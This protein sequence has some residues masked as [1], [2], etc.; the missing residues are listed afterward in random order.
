V[1]HAL[2][3]PTALALYG[4]AALVAVPYALPA[5]LAVPFAPALSA[6]RLR[7][8]SPRAAETPSSAP[9]AEPT[10]VGASAL[11][12]DTNDSGDR[13]DGSER[14]AAIEVPPAPKRPIEDEGTDGHA[15]DGFFARLARTEAKAPGART[16]IL[17]FGDSV[18]AADWITSTLRRDL[19][20][21]FGDAGHGY[22]LPA[23]AWPGYFHQDIARFA[24]EGWKASRV[25]GPFEP[26]GIYGLGGVT[27]VAEGPGSLAT[28]AT[29]DPSS[30]LARANGGIGTA[31]ARFVVSFRQAP[32]GGTLRLSV[33]GQ[34][35][36]DLSTRADKP[37][38]GRHTL[39][40][41]DGAHKLTLRSQGGGPVGVLGV[42]ALRDE[43]GVVVDSLGI[44]G[45]RLRFL[46]KFAP[47][48]FAEALQSRDPALL[49]FSYGAN[50]S[51]D[52]FAYSMAD[53]ERTAREVLTRA[54]TALP[55]TSCLLVGPMDRADKKGDS[56]ATRPVIPELD[57]I[58]RK[59][60]KELGCAF[61]DTFEAMGGLGSMGVWVQ[62]GLGG[63]DLVHP[64]NE[65]AAVLAGY[66]EDA[67]LSDYARWRARPK[68]VT[69]PAP[70]ANQAAAP[71]P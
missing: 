25:V 7:L 10:A 45:C 67:L 59:L 14:G 41:P 29:I 50:E 42:D 37:G 66:V 15:L 6:G 69:V 47:D 28:V 63:K 35:P 20:R 65:G 70:S 27:L 40:A 68:T 30:R 52:G 23:N 46:G 55:E 54:R 49:V 56:Y 32:D 11:V 64:T 53:Y 24:S 44:V 13:D 4:L 36:V 57:R 61:F 19:Q 21:R 33:D 60:A 62:R 43:P 3:S 48:V 16:R 8:L 9:I 2:R 39:T 17:Y 18:I 51:E 22:V 26:N 71:A 5:T 34:P 1:T 31:V 12:T 38:V 58:Q